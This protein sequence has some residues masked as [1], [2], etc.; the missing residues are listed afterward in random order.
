MKGNALLHRS[1]FKLAAFYAGMMG[2]L[3]SLIG[4]ETYYF[5]EQH[6]HQTVD[7]EISF[8]ADTIH[9]SLEPKLVL[10]DKI[11]D[12]IQEVFPDFCMMPRCQGTN[13]T[14]TQRHITNAFA[15]VDQYYLILTDNTGKVRATA[16]KVPTNVR[17]NLHQTLTWTT[18]QETT[19]HHYYR[20]YMMV[21]H[22]RSNHYPQ[23]IW[24]RLY[25]GRNTG[26]LVNSLQ[27]L[28]VGLLLSLP[29]AL[30]VMS[31]LSWHFAGRAML[32]LYKAYEHQQ[33][34]SASVAHELRTPLAINQLN[35]E[36]KINQYQSTDP[37]LVIHL[38]EL[39]RQNSRLAGIVNDLLLLAQL[40]HPKVD[41]SYCYLDEI[42]EDVAEDLS[43]LHNSHQITVCIPSHLCPVT[44]RGHSDRLTRLV[45][46]LVENAIKYT[47]SSGE[48]TISISETAR[49]YML[50]VR[51]TGVGI[52]AQELA[53]I[54][55]RF[56]R[57]SVS[58]DRKTGGTG[59]GL[60]MVKSIASTYGAEVKVKSTI[61]FGSVFSVKFPRKHYHH[62]ALGNIKLVMSTAIQKVFG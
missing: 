23:N 2:I 13:S 35:I 21:I 25:I 32:P 15:A 37:S 47:P 43:S 17:N 10:P 3:Y 28:Q 59:L 40:D 55:D 52:P 14:I 20:Q 7:R 39:H 26:N 49:Y 51:D 22:S 58:R 44:I 46:N 60:T 42:V 45:S 6:H 50:Q 11:D 33:L 19:S 16:G 41:D 4:I 27:A 29:V 34:F 61:G 38:E 5:T 62:W 30:V 48:I 36:K 1:Q 56:Y 57:I 54:F 9:N 31:G 53:K 18:W 24:G 12:S 8:I